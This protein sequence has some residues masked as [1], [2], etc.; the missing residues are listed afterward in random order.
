MPARRGELVVVERKL[1]SAWAPA[2]SA[3]IGRGGRFR[4]DVTNAGL[5][6]IR[7]GGDAGPQVRVGS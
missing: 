7:Y 6:R 3:T 1:G 2:G 4:F 5:Y